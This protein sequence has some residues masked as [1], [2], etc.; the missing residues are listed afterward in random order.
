M[1]FLAAYGLFLAKA[2]SIIVLMLLPIAVIALGAKQKKNAGELSVEVKNLNERYLELENIVNEAVLSEE[3]FKKRGKELK[4]AEKS[5]K[6]SISKDEESARKRVFVLDFMGDIEASEVSGLSE[7]IDAVALLAKSDDEVVLRLESMGGVVHG[8]GLA[9]SQLQRL[10]D[11]KIPLTIAVDKVAASGGYMMACLADNIIAAPF[12]VI[13]SVGVVTQFTN[14]YKL[15]KKHDVD[16]ETMTAGEYKHTVSRMGEIT[17]KGREKLKE[18]LEDTHVL[19]K[20]FV[21]ERRPSLDIDKIATGEVWYGARALE[22][23]L[24]DSLQTSD[25][26][27]LEKHKD[28]DLYHIVTEKKKSL[29]EK[30]GLSIEYSTDRLLLKWWNRLMSRPLT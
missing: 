19:F 16:V 12:A 18:E 17:D 4:K 9:A 2:F 14:I 28:H 29:M 25:E 30:I 24:V 5:R 26:Y 21:S 27:L 13:G 11:R 22:R 6:K 7:K 10:K 3:E 1:E 15:L 23:N 8:Y 20:E